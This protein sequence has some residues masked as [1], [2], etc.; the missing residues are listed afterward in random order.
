MTEFCHITPTEYLDL[1]AHNRSH[2]LSL[3]H[4]IEQDPVYANWYKNNAERNPDS[5]NIMDNSAFEMYKQGRDMYPA[6][7]LLEM[8]T[9]V[10][11]DYVVLSD[12][13]SQE[14][15]HTIEAAYL[16]APEIR[17]NGFGTF[18]VPQSEVGDLED[19]IF[20][21]KWAAES[22][23]IDYVGVSILAV[24]NAYG[25]ERGN[26]L[27]R[28]LSRWWFMNE[29]NK[30]GVLKH[31]KAR[32]KKIHF[33]GMVDGPNEIALVKDYLWA[34]D[35]WD[36]SAA[37][38][39]GINDIEFDQSPSGLVDGKYEVEVDFNHNTATLN[40]M[41]KAM[42]NCFYIDQ[43]IESIQGFNAIEINLDPWR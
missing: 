4:L 13:P 39:A 5:V 2:H 3:A 6:H 34:I 35:T 19:L 42:K 20:A 16:L 25:V 27:Q 17:R 32:G 23:L 10:D 38:W 33:L 26:K 18:F 30:R 12:Y 37:V 9:K 28:F 43:L 1:F 36:S 11:A 22:P 7:K 24:P 8:A 21:F 14:S 31:L 40:Q 15:M 41:A 29:L